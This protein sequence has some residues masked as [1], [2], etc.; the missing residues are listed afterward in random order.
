MFDC[1]R[2]LLSQR[3]RRSF[4]S[5][6]CSYFGEF[7]LNPNR[8][9]NTSRNSSIPGGHHYS[10]TSIDAGPSI[11]LRWVQSMTGQPTRQTD[12][13]LTDRRSVCLGCVVVRCCPTPPPPF[14][15]LKGGIFQVLSF[16]LNSN[17]FRK[18]FA[19]FYV[20]FIFNILTICNFL[21][22]ASWYENVYV[23]HT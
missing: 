4:F 3:Q 16:Q 8:I 13:K 1:F 15:V 14:M 12:N 2:I 5:S 11:A 22:T 18:L 21:I 23:V 20:S 6:C 17:Q 9:C 7:K 10:M 19:A